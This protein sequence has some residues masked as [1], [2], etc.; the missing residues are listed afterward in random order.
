MFKKKIKK[1]FQKKFQT[2]FK[3]ISKNFK[4]NLKKNYNFKKILINLNFFFLNLIFFRKFQTI[5]KI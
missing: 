4:K 3:Q 1:K 2:N 5:L